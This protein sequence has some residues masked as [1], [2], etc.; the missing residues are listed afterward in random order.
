[1][2]QESVSIIFVRLQVGWCFL[3]QHSGMRYQSAW[4]GY[5]SWREWMIL[6]YVFTCRPR[7]HA[8]HAV[9]VCKPSLIHKTRSVER[10]VS[11]SKP[12]QYRHVLQIL[13]SL[14]SRFSYPTNARDQCNQTQVL[15]LPSIHPY[16]PQH[17]HSPPPNPYPE[18][19]VIIRHFPPE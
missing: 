7:T 5:L 8:A 12:S 16:L 15:A 18:P 11:S 2:A 19:L 3:W 9:Q 6:P 10:S 14:H 17:S 13:T 1:M 4:I